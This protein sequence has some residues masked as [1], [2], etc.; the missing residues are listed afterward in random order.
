MAQVFFDGS[1]GVIFMLLL[2]IEIYTGIPLVK[3]LFG[4]LS[5]D[6]ARQAA[7]VVIFMNFLLPTLLSLV[8]DPF[9]RLLERFWP[10]LEG[11]GVVKDKIYS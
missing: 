2:Y 4:F 9:Y 11:G 10:P 5:E 7:F 1:A 3:A 8:L 6:I